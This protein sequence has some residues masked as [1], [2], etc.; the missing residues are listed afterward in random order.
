MGECLETGK[1]PNMIFGLSG[2]KPFLEPW[3][4]VFCL[5][6]IPGQVFVK[7]MEAWVSIDLCMLAKTLGKN[8]VFCLVGLDVFGWDLSIPAIF[9]AGR[10]VNFWSIEQDIYQSR[11]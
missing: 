11:S 1:L 5:K 3:K 10:S 9:E 2:T 4:T 7:M 6:N 8:A